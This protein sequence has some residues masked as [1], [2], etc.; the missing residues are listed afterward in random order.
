MKKLFVYLIIVLAGL[1]CLQC[2]KIIEPF[3]TN[4][5]PGSDD[6]NPGLDPEYPDPGS[7]RT[8][9]QFTAA[10]KSL[11]NSTNSFGLKL[12]KNINNTTPNDKNLFISPLSVS[13]ALGMAYNGA[14]GET[15][16]AIA[17][18]LELPELSPIEINL[19][20]KNLTQI[21]GNLDEYVTFKIANSIWYRNGFP[22][23]QSFLD[24]N[25]D[26]FSASVRAL[27]FN[28]SSS[29][30]T[31][32]NWVDINT[33]GKITNIINPP[34]D[35]LTMMYLINAIYFKGGW[36]LPFDSDYNFDMDFTRED[37]SK[38]LRTFMRADT[39]FSFTENDLFQAI[40]LM[41]GDSSFSIAI[42]LPRP[43]HT[44]NDILS[45]LNNESWSSWMSQL[46]NQSVYLKLPKFKFKYDI[47]LKSILASM[48]MN[49]AFQPFVADFTP[50]ADVNDLHISDVFHK[51]FVQLDEEGTE[52]AAV[53]VVIISTT[54]ID[55]TPYITINRPFLFAIRERVSG[56][57]I[58]MGKVADPVWE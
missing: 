10:E 16:E 18:T 43:E 41:Y 23:K 48:G 5:R 58:F 49:I 3:N 37:G 26:Y 9:E 55:P 34:I 40:E 13:Y 33:N 32:N 36:S 29:A 44:V 22:V 8:P 17:S 28:N 31:I 38:V 25:Q 52:A 14:G 2:S 7:D 51:T 1:I 27:D 4:V 30:E 11:V 15:K 54:S 56:T 46:E 21:L 53:T 39:T 35:P 47:S 19:S 50:I 42:L 12:F 20:Y 57:I 24:I 6:N 45:Q